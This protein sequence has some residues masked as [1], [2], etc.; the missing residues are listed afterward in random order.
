M[1]QELAVKDIR[2]GDRLP[3]AGGHTG[4]TAQD[5][6]HTVSGVT[7]LQVQYHP[8]GGLGVREWDNPELKLML[9]RDDA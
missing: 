9:E 7:M 6:A 5:D 4:W 2:K 1:L 3:S 8:D